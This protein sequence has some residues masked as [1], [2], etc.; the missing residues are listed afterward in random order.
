M[1]FR[2]EL[3]AFPLLDSL[4]QTRAATHAPEK[5]NSSRVTMPFVKY[6]DFTDSVLLHTDD[7]PR[8]QHKGELPEGQEENSP[9][10]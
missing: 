8:A 7:S 9:W 2:F 3:P 10:G 4:A 1:P 5:G 6:C